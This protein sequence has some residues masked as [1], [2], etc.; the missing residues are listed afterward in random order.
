LKSTPASSHIN[1]AAAG[2]IKAFI[3][4]LLTD[5]QL[6]DQ[7]LD[8]NKTAL[9]RGITLVE[10]NTKKGVKTSGSLF[11]LT[12]GQNYCFAVPWTNRNFRNLGADPE[13]S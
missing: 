13:I 7:L 4:K 10:S 11:A 3:K 2:K 8:R 9:S 6:I 12:N 1:D 5:Q